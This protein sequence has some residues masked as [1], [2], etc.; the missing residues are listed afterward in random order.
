MSILHGLK[1]CH[2]EIV[3]LWLIFATLETF[4]YRPITRRIFYPSWAYV[5]PSKSLWT[6]EGFWPWEKGIES[7][8]QNQ[9]F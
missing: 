6:R 2:T 8:S 9:T 1:H 5:S 7:L 4:I 3:N